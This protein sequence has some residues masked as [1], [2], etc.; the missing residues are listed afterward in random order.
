MGRTVEDVAIA[1]GTMTGIDSSD[2][3]TLASEGKYLTDYIRI[4]YSRWSER[5]TDW[6]SEKGNGLFR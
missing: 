5:Q 6:S 4:S 2:T 1:L 3:K